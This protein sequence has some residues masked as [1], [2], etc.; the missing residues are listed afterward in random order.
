[1]SVLRREP[2]VNLIVVPPMEFGFLPLG[3]PLRDLTGAIPL[4]EIDDEL[5]LY[6]GRRLRSD[7]DEY[8][9]DWPAAVLLCIEHMLSIKEGA[10]W[11]RDFA[12]EN[13]YGSSAEQAEEWARLLQWVDAHYCLFFQPMTRDEP[14]E[15]PYD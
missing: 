12:K 14:E 2:G 6:F 1:M 3:V 7:E 8:F 10:Q 4:E 11:L 5:R 9:R 13:P 15:D